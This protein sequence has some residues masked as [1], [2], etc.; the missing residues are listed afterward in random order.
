[1][2][3]LCHRANQTLFSVDASVFV[4]CSQSVVMRLL[5]LNNFEEVKAQ[6][7]YHRVV[8]DSTKS[9]LYI[10]REHRRFLD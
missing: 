2:A 6:D 5:E 8:S 9:H 4:E 1:M 7:C 3:I 10:M